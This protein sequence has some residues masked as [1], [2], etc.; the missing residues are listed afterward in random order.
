MTAKLMDEYVHNSC[1]VLTFAT[2]NV[3]PCCR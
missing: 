1:T 2:A 3:A